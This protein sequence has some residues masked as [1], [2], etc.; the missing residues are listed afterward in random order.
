MTTLSRN[1]FRFFHRL[2]VR[3]A[4]VDMQRIVFNPH[5]LTYIDTAMSGYW[6]A[7][8]LPYTLTMQ[9]LGAEL[10]LKKVTIDFQAS[11]QLDDGIEV[12]LH[13]SKIGTSSM[14]FEGAIFRGSDCLL[15]AQL[16]Y[17]YA[18]AKT[19]KSQPV[20]HSLRT[21]VHAFEAGEPMLSIRFGNWDSVQSEAAPL[22]ETVFVQ[23]QKVPP[24]EEWDAADASALHAVVTNRLGLPVATGRLLPSE[25]KTARIGR[26]AVLRSLR[27]AGVGEWLLR[28]LVEQAVGREDTHIVLHAQC[29][30]Q[31]FYARQG[32]VVQG[33]PFNE[34]GIAHVV[35]VKSLQKSG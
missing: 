25:N 31:S 19:Q 3:W 21:V 32:F 24:E 29:H 16:V 1:N 23:E 33:E 11:A 12:G 22:R 28:Q 4:E 8:A 15:L 9:S 17:V 10:F 20:P 2:R 27:G 13:C 14:T 30:A 18:D 26:M 5:Y 7:L 35:M 34:V 6:N